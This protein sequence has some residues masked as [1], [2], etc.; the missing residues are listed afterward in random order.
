M[1]KPEGDIDLDVNGVGLDAENRGTAQA[2]EHEDS[3]VQRP[4]RPPF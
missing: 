4:V 2:R 1:G 3:D